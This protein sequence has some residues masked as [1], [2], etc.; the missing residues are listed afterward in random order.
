MSQE[1][2]R[3]MRRRKTTARRSAMADPA[4]SATETQK[5]KATKVRTKPPRDMTQATRRVVPVMTEG[6]AGAETNRGDRSTPLQNRVDPFGQIFKSPARGLFM[7][8]R[9]GRIHDPALQ[10][11]YPNRRWTSKAWICCSPTFKDRRRAVWKESYTELFFLDEVTALAAGHRP[12]FECRRRDARAFAAAFA[13]GNG[14]S[15]SPTAGHMDKVLHEER[16]DLE[17]PGGRDKRLLV[18]FIDTL[19][20]GAMI[21]C[22][23]PD[24]LA[25]AVRGEFVFPWSPQGW[26]PPIARP[27][28]R[29][30][31]LVTP[32]SIVM[33]L[34]AGYHPQWH[35]SGSIAAFEQRAAGV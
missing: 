30:V 3:P 35:E 4:H 19:P 13:S 33:A 26:G 23:A 10:T 29:L 17:A 32:P 6:K 2:T 11:L 14:L 9:G 24:R 21:A 18:A 22:D 20:D 16:L 7:G 27:R 34:K 31:T 28:R 1:S 15:T 5:A 12:C 25:Y 8:N